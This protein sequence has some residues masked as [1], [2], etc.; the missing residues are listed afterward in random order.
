[1]FQFLKRE[2][3]KYFSVTFVSVPEKGGEEIINELCEFN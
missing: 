1:L 2:K 3:R